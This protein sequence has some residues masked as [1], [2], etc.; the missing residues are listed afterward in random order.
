MQLKFGGSHKLD[1]TEKVPEMFVKRSLNGNKQPAN[2]VDYGEL[3][4]QRF[5][6]KVK[7]ENEKGPEAFNNPGVRH[8]RS[9]RRF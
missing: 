1:R 4:R 3:G 6:P 8:T 9:V 7:R 5:D 2:C